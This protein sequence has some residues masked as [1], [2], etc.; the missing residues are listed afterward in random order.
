ML[1]LV[2]DTNVF[3]SGL[4]NSPKCRRIIEKLQN[5]SFLLITSSDILEELI[6]VLGR[7]K[8]RKVI[9]RETIDK[10]IISIESQAILVRPSRKINIIKE[11]PDDNRF[12]EAALEGK[13]DFIISGDR[14]LLKLGKFKNIS[15]LTPNEFLLLIG[16]R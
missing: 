14:H 5:S 4:L 11:D 16:N 12:I 10:L 9:S 1:K 2:I 13:A 6:N 7:P 3:I 15:I 8:F